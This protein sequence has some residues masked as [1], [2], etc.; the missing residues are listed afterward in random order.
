VG[1]GGVGVCGVAIDDGCVVV[2]NIVIIVVI[3]CLFIISVFELFSSA[4]F[5]AEAR[6]E[7][8]SIHCAMVHVI[9]LQRAA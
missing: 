4:P 9:L 5:N 3:C 8:M 6:A 2:S 7:M 1:S